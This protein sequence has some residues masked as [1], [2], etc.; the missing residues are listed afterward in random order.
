MYGKKRYGRVNKPAE[1][2]KVVDNSVPTFVC[3]KCSNIK[4]INMPHVELTILEK[5]QLLCYTKMCK[6]CSNWLMGDLKK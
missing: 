1:Q 6:N 2:P 4:N 5:G 3:P